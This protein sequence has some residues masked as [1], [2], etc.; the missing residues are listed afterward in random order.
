MFYPGSVA[1]GRQEGIRKRI[2]FVPSAVRSKM[3]FGTAIIYYI[4]KERR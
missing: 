2:R 3:S 1:G 4:L